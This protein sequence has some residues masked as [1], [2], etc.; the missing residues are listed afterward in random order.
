[1]GTIYEMKLQLRITQ[2][3]KILVDACH[4]NGTRRVGI[5]EHVLLVAS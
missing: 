2:L 5:R 4:T 3:F 1:M